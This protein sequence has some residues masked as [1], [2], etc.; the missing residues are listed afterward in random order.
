MEVLL[1]ILSQDVMDEELGVF[2][3]QLFLAQGATW[4]IQRSD[5]CVTGGAYLGTLHLN[6][7]ELKAWKRG[8]IEFKIEQPKGIR[9]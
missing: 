3:V 4:T 7:E 6:R 8:E 9:L 5:K 2:R 1:D